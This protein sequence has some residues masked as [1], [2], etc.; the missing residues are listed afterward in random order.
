[1]PEDADDP[2]VQAMRAALAQAAQ[3][4]VERTAEALAYTKEF[5]ALWKE[6]VNTPRASNWYTSIKTL[7]SKGLPIEEMADSVMVTGAAAVVPGRKF[8]YFCGVANTKL[9]AIEARAKEIA[10]EGDGMQIPP[11]GCDEYGSLQ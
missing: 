5:D 10:E 4:A 6:H 3:E 7:H 8:A 1:M 9:R 11:A 2:A